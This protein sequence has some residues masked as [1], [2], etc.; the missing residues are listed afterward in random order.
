[1]INL[2]CR[3]DFIPRVVV[4]FRALFVDFPAILED[5][6]TCVVIELPASSSLNLGQYHWNQLETIKYRY[7]VHQIDFLSPS[8]SF[9][10]L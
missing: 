10:L 4:D 8:T 9:D 7:R 2:R 6:S 5:F 1:M 3:V